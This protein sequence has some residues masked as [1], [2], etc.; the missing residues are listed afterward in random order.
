MAYRIC[1]IDSTGKITSV[2]EESYQT[3]TTSVAEIIFANPKSFAFIDEE[4]LS[5][6]LS[7]RITGIENE[8]TIVSDGMN[9]GI[10]TGKQIGRAHV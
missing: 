10:V 4:S 2:S 1:T 6:L 3:S 8:S 7:D 9:S 5:S